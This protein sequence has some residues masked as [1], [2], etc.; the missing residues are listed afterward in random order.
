M[1][2]FGRFG[3]PAIHP[4][5]SP[6]TYLRPSRLEPCSG[7]GHEYPGLDFRLCVRA[8][9]TIEMYSRPDSY[10]AGAPQ[11]VLSVQL[12]HHLAVGGRACRRVQSDAA[13]AP[14]VFSEG[15]CAVRGKVA[16]DFF[17]LTRALRSHSDPCNA[18]FSGGGA[19]GVRGGPLAISLP[20]A[21]PGEIAKGAATPQMEPPICI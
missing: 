1:T 11:S 21:H 13:A 12:R 10:E 5:P 19:G 20:P 14:P 9:R 15:R 4:V 3:D 18:A 7:F 16:C 17:P 2:A 8:R 6:L